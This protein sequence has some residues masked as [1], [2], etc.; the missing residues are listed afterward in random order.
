MYKT[1]EIASDT[2][3]SDNVIHQRLLF[4]YELAQKEV[5]GTVLEV[6]C[7]FG[8]GVET[9]SPKCDLFIG[10]DKIGDLINMLSQKH[11]KH[12]FI[13]TNIPP[14]PV[15]DESVDYVVT[16]QVIEHIKDDHKFMQEIYRVLKP[17]GKAIITTPNIDW[18]LTRNPWHVREYNPKQMKEIC[19]KYFDKVSVKGISGNEK[20][21]TYYE[22]NK[23]SVRRITK[24]DILNLQYRLPRKLLQMP[25][26]FFNRM[27]RKRLQKDNNSLVADV[28]TNDYFLTEAEKG[29]DYYCLLEK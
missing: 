4:P 14:F 6:G 7:G 19:Q 20:V 16:F 15:E 13:Q 27:S 17:G 25:Y 28:T 2:I 12:K 18:T 3:V 22:E 23:K 26:D 11:P 8:R 10:L 1:T 9:L 5:S 24:F 29:F 21:M